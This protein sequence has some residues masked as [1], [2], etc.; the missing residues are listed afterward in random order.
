M[1]AKQKYLTEIIDE[2]AHLVDTNSKDIPTVKP[3]LQK[4]KPGQKSQRQ[5]FQELATLS[6][7][8]IL[9]CFG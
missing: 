6:N 4:T 9:P 3:F 2:S 5:F 7:M 8:K 1:H